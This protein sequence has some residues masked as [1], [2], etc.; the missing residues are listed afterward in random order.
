MSTPAAMA[1]TAAAFGLRLRC[2]AC[3]R[4]LPPAGDSA[5][6]CPHCGFEV[7]LR[8]GIWRALA[9]DRARH[10]AAFATSYT[11]IRSQEGRGSPDPAY[12]LDLPYSDRTGRHAWEWAIR[13]CSYRHLATNLGPRLAAA[14]GGGLDILD[15]GAGNGWLSHRLTAMGHRPV[16]VDLLDHPDDGLGAARHYLAEDVRF[17]RYQADMDH[18]PFCEAQFDLAIYNA[19]FHYS[20]DYRSTLAE[21]L[22]CLR[23]DG[24]VAILDSP[25]YAQAVSGDRMVEEKHQ[26]FQRQFGQRSDALRSREYLVQETM[27]SLAAALGLRWERHLPDYGLA[28]RLRP[29]KARLLRRREPSRFY[30]WLGYRL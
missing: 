23:V 3:A 28:W 14:R 18:L 2:P 21:A 4:G 5:I 24:A 12:Y 15:L 25:F 6:L 1:P 30:L 27:E 20:E 19:V 10:F 11:T 8:D 16:A 9:A 26:R 17:S 22:R 29:W 13:G 7:G